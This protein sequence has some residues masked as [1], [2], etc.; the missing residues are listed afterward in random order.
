M[1]LKGVC[2]LKTR[3]MLKPGGGLRAVRSD[4]EEVT[5]RGPKGDESC[6]ADTGRGVV[7]E[8]ERTSF[9]GDGTERVIACTCQKRVRRAINQRLDILEVELP[10]FDV[11]RRHRPLRNPLALYIRRFK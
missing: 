6:V 8:N 9:E 3:F 11:F 5:L 1:G 4:A 7:L 10:T 2:P